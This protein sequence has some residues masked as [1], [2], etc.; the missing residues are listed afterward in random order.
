MQIKNYKP[1][2][3]I[4]RVLLI[5][6]KKLIDSGFEFFAFILICQGIEYLGNFYDSNDLNDF[7]K[8]ECRF[9]IALKN[10]FSNIFY[11]NNQKWLFEHLRGSLI[12]QIRPSDDMLLTSLKNGCPENMHLKREKKHQRRIIIIESLY[13]DFEKACKKFVREIKDKPAH[14]NGR[15]KYNESHFQIFDISL[16]NT[17]TVSGT[18]I[19]Q[20]FD[21]NNND[22]LH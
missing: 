12:H 16:E 22:D 17:F 14:F 4:N 3:F 2:D 7:G 6:I 18:T 13:N 11:K 10:L 1:E 19:C 15:D 9:K 8:S 21:S 20:K 5:D